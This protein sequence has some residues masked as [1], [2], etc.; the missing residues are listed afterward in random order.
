[1]AMLACSDAMTCRVGSIDP[2]VVRRHEQ[3][4]HQQHHRER[5][6]PDCNHNCPPVHART[7]AGLGWLRVH[8]TMSHLIAA[9]YDAFEQHDA[10]RLRR[11]ADL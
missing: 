9:P 3:R 7:I 8:Y 11:V 10:E 4:E 2:S 5:A 6:H 1:M